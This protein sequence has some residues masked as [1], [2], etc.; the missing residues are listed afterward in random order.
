MCLSK[1]ARLLHI[2]EPQTEHNLRVADTEQADY[3]E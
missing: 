3:G 1:A 2:D